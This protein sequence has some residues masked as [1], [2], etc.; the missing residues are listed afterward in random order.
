MQKY[1]ASVKQILDRSP[2][3]VCRPLGQ[4]RSPQTLSKDADAAYVRGDV[5]EAI[6]LYKEL[7]EIQPDCIVVTPR[8]RLLVRAVCMVF[9]RYLRATRQQAAYSKVI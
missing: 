7:I 6:R 4:N 9:D 2:D 5:Q 1:G 3:K 8:G